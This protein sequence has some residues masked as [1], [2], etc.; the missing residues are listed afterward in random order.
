[1]NM[2]LTI[3]FA[4][5]ATAWSLHQIAQRRRLR[6]ERARRKTYFANIAEGTRPTGNFTKLTDTAIGTRNFLVKIGS[7]SDHVAA[8]AA[9]TDIPLGVCT[10]EAPASEELVN[11]ALLGVANGTLRVVLGGTVAAGDMLQSNGDGTA[12][13][14]LTTTGTFYNIGRALQA[15][16]SGDVIEFA[17][18][19]PLK[20]VNP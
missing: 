6:H 10:D 7:D 16:V 19:F 20:V 18:T 17:H 5:L 8:S 9:N 13:K 3:P 15:G 4:T 12:I 2:F 1:M 14:L 11:V